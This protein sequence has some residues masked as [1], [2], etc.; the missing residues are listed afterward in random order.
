M[1]KKLFT[2]MEQPWNNILFCI[3]Y[4]DC[5]KAGD[6]EQWGKLLLTRTFNFREVE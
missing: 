3:C 6:F 4:V 2:Q 1:C 5:S